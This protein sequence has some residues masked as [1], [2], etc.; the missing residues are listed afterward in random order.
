MK[1][2]KKVNLNFHCGSLK[3]EFH[4]FLLLIKFLQIPLLG[5]LV[6]FLPSAFVTS[7][8]LILNSTNFPKILLSTPDEGSYSAGK[9]FWDYSN[10][11]NSEKYQRDYKI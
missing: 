3:D 5:A 4:M 1:T 2:T 11:I 8:V 7:C 10:H 9:H 6:F